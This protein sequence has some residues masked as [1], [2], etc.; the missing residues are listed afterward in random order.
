MS[1]Q[2]GLQGRTIVFTGQPRSNEVLLEVQRLG[3][4]AKLF[5]L[6]RTHEVISSQDEIFFKK[7]SGYDWLIFTSQNAV[8]FFLQKM[9][10]YNIHLKEIKVKIAAVGTSTA[11]AIEDVGLQV[12]F[13]PTNFSAEAFVEQFP[14]VSD[15]IDTCL[16]VRGSL[17]KD[18]L[19]K[20]LS[21]QVDEWTVYETLPNMDNSQGLSTYIAQQL[22]VFIAFASPS[23][24][25]VF[26][27]TIACHLG[28][29]P[30]KIAAIGHVTATTLE[31]YGATV[32][33]QPKIYTWMALI[34]EIAKWKDDSNE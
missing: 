17:A 22:H 33:I 10:R 20:G 12:S 2:T 8:S 23:A 6:I 30:F 1:N 26:A 32:H 4:E 21:Q 7:L 27:D 3:G 15:S 5:P 13:I 31:K 28:W 29:T 16:F 14:Q 11:S 25:E 18:T 24:V 9:S 19:K 34:Q